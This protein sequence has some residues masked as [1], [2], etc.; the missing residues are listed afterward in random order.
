MAEAIMFRAQDLDA[1]DSKLYAPK[2]A[3]L[4]ARKL[5]NIKTDI[6]P[7]AETYSYDVITRSGA[8]RIL[9]PGADDIPL[10]EADLDRHTVDIYSIAVGFKIGIQ[11]MRAAQMAGRDIDTTKA[12]IARRAIA[13]KENQLAFKGDDDYNISG[14]LNTTGIQTYAVPENGVDDTGAATSDW[15]YKTGLQIVADIRN[16]RAKVNKLPGHTADTL[17]LPTDEYE[18]LQVPVNEYDTRTIMEYIG[19]MGWFTTIEKTDDLVG[20]G[21]EGS[22]C[23]LVFDSSPEVAEL[24]VPMDLTRHEEEYAFPNIR[25]PV[26]ERTGGVIIRYPMAFCR[27]DGING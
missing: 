15:N 25:V 16:A 20:A 7:G 14:V 12:G 6:D 5:F 10:V 13:E 19:A 8:A 17:V 21:A 3:E 22:N 1:I 2:E 27:G 18:L 4:L 24:L 11:E 9:A 23:F 26:E